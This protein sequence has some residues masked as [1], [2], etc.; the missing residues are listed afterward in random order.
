VNSSLGGGSKDTWVIDTGRPEESAAEAG[1][2]LAMAMP[3]AASAPEMVA[4][5]RQI[6]PEQ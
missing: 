5:A 2:H 6:G 3:E 4:I 1:E